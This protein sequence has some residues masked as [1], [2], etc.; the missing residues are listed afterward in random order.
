M[1]PYRFGYLGSASEKR[2]RKSDE[3]LYGLEWITTAIKSSCQT[4]LCR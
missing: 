4:A 2:W 1:V 3:R